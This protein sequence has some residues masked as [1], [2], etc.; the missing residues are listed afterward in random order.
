MADHCFVSCSVAKLKDRGMRITKPRLAVLSILRKNPKGLTPRDLFEFVAQ[1][2]SGPQCDQVTIY[3]I[4][5][6]FVQLGVAH[7][8]PDGR[9][10]GCQEDLHHGHAVD[11]PALHIVLTCRECCHFEEKVISQQLE[12]SLRQYLKSVCSGFDLP[13]ILQGESMCPS[14][15]AKQ[16]KEIL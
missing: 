2:L 6:A 3:R 16:R 5:D 8:L 10:I 11:E 13:H 9:V 15:S 12:S 1:D 4:V 14:C 7:R